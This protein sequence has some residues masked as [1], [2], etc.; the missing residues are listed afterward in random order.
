MKYDG[1]GDKVLVASTRISVS[2]TSENQ[3]WTVAYADVQMCEASTLR[4]DHS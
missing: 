1:D 3:L 2:E 4:T